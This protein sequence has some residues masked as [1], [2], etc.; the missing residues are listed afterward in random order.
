LAFSFSHLC[1]AA[2]IS[3]SSSFFFTASFLLATTIAAY[4]ISWPSC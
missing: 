3:S 4:R 1:T 2:L